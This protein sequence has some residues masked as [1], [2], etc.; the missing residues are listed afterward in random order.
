MICRFEAMGRRQG[1]DTPVGDNTVHDI[2]PCGEGFAFATAEPSF[3]LF[4]SKGDVSILGGRRSADMREKLGRAL[5]LS[6]D[7]SLV[8]FGLGFGGREPIAFSLSDASVVESLT[9]SRN[10]VSAQPSGLPVANWHNDPSPAFN[11]TKLALDAYETSRALAGQPG[12]SGFALGTDFSVR[13]YDAAGFATMAPYGSGRRGAGHCFYA[14]R[15]NSSR[16]LHR[17]HDP[18]AALER[19][20]GAAGAVRRGAD[21]ALGRLDADRLL[22]GL[23]RAA[24]T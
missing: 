2:Q 24:R 10:L 21:A 8:R 4:S 9:V 16:C 11:G 18:L 12:D 5:A 17:R 6:P 20:A 23:R 7:A 1:V 22:H 3:G 15:R 14:G 13:A 19:R